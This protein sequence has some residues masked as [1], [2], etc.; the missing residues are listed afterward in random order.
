MS[1]HVPIQNLSLLVLILTV[2]GWGQVN[3]LTQHNDNARTGA[4]LEE[5]ILNTSNVRPGR[6]GE[7]FSRAVD[8]QIY[9]QPLYVSNLAM[10]DGGTHNVV[11]VATEHNSV[12]A[13]D[14]DDPDQSTPLWKVNLGP[15]NVTPNGDFGCSPEQCP[16]G[17]YH[18]LFPELGI[19]GTPVID[20]RAQTLYLVAFSKEFGVYHQRLHA[21]DITTGAEKVGAPVEITGSVP[22]SGDGSVDGRITFDPMQHLQ[23]P[24]L[25]LSNGVLYIAFASHADYNPYHGWVFAYDAITLTQLGIYCTTPNGGA[26]GIWQSNQGPAADANGNVYFMTGNNRVAKPDLDL[27]NL[28]E[29]FVKLSLGAGKRLTVTDYFTPCNQ[30]CLDKGDTDLGSAGPLLIPDTDPPLLVG[31]GKQG[32]AYLLNQDNLGQYQGGQTPSCPAITT[33]CSTCLDDR[34]VQRFQATTGASFSSPI[35]WKQPGRSPGLFLG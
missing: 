1:R 23:R 8:G 9:A 32:R 28:G 15:A 25:L 6:F 35:Y 21:L 14:A 20:L 11:Y 24:A 33:E 10:R 5:T 12:Y 2:S 31:V 13:F 7:L 30:C 22:G 16:F 18:D 26:G 34:I 19:T 27:P 3:V 17:P 4:N 29:T